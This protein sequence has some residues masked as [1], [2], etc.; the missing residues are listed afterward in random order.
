MQASTLN[1]LAKLPALHNRVT[2]CQVERQLR[3]HDGVATVRH[4]QQNCGSI[5]AAA[6]PSGESTSSVR[7]FRCPGSAAHESQPAL[8]R[9]WRRARHSSPHALHS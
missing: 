3:T 1:R 6:A 4:A 2:A 5:R 7:S 9:C 8:Q